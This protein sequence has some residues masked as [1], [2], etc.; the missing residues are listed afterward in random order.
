MREAGITA[1]DDGDDGVSVAHVAVDDRYLG[2]ISYSDEVRP[3]AATLCASLRERGIFRLVIVSGDRRGVVSH[4]AHEVGIT[5]HVGAVFPERKAEIVRE[6]QQAGHVVAVVGDGINDS[7]A[8]AYA[9][10]S[11]AVRDG[12]DLARETADVVLHGSLDGLLVA[13]DRSR[14]A[15]SLLRQNI[16]LAVG[17]NLAGMALASA[18]ALGPAAATAINNGSAIAA[19]LNGLRPLAAPIVG[20]RHAQRALE[21][22]LGRTNAAERVDDRIA[23][24]VAG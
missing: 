12:T 22:R 17:P 2:A 11:V 21:R 6:L 15:M 13:I 8:L 9:D 7:P 23:N 20:R 16:A 10:V 5:E 24:A 4:L 1:D 18:G 3:E 14:D 19:G